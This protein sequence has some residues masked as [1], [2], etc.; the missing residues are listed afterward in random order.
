MKKIL[1]CALGLSSYAM[2]QTADS[3]SLEVGYSND[4][5]YSFEN[6]EVLNTAADN[7]DLAFELDVFGAGVRVNNSRSS[8]WVYPGA[9]TDW[10]SLDTNGMVSSWENNLNDY[11]TWALG[12]LNLA[13]DQSSS[14]DLGW[15]EYNTITHQIEGSRIFVIELNDGSFRKLFIEDLAAGAYAFK[16]DFIDNSN[17]VNTIITKANYTGKNFVYFDVLTGT[18]I[19]REPLSSSWDVLFTNYILELAPGYIGSVTGALQNLN[20]QVSKVENT[21][22]ATSSYGTFETEINTIGYDWKSF[23]MSTFSYDIVNDL[24]YFVQLE[25]GDVWKLVFTDFGGSSTGKIYFTKEKIE[26]AGVP[27]IDVNI[28]IYPNPVQNAL[29]IESSKSLN[30]IEIIS[31][32]GERV[33]ELDKQTTSSTSIDLSQLENGVYFLKALTEDHQSSI[34]KI[35]VQH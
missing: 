22:V 29:N 17:E 2:S 18:V 10:T 14:T 12:A 26:S 15:G 34:Q 11:S 25:N 30:S 28:S 35:I 24:S 7:W 13:A 21:P 5:Y 23:N 4:S 32:Q 31:A 19:D 1:L 16:T 9:I 20:V 6:G 3:I 27:S 33:F 8:V